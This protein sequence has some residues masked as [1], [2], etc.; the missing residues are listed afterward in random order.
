MYTFLISISSDNNWQLN[1]YELRFTKIPVYP[2]Y[3]T[4][5][6]TTVDSNHLHT[7]QQLTT[8]TTHASR[9]PVYSYSAYTDCTHNV[10]VLHASTSKLAWKSLHSKRTKPMYGTSLSN[11]Y[12]ETVTYSL[13]TEKSQ[14]YLLDRVNFATK[15]WRKSR[16]CNSKFHSRH[17]FTKLGDRVSINLFFSDQKLSLVPDIG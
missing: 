2:V 3:Y 15:N 12:K 8:V 4:T 14:I 6:Q 7:Q 5:V 11:K 17:L 16:I 1:V 13:L 9:R 10:N